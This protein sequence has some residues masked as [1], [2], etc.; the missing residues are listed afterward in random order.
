MEPYPLSQLVT[1]FILLCFGLVVRATL[2]FLETSITAMR[3]YRLKE[4]AHT[5]TQYLPLLQILEK[6]PQR[7][8]I[9][10]IVAN[11]FVDVTAA[12]LAT[13]IMGKIFMHIGFSGS[14][15]FTVGIAFATICIIVF[16]EILPKSFAK[17]RSEQS[18]QSMLW[19]I[20]L[21]YY[22][23]YPLVFILVRFSDYVM[24]KIGGKEALE[25]GTQW[26]SSEREI[27]FLINYIHEQ[28]LLELEKREMLQNIFEMGSTPTKEV[29]V[30]AT[31]IVSLEVHTPIEKVFE[32]FSKHP[33][34][35]IPVYEGQPDNFIGMAH[36]KDLFIMFSKNET[37]S[38][39]ELIRPIMF[40]PESMKVNQLLGKFREK[41]MHIGIVINE[42]G[43]VTGLVTLEDIIEEIVGEISDEHEPTMGKIMPLQK[44]EWIVDA[45][46]PLNDLG[47]FLGITFETENSVSLA[48]FLAEMLQHIPA[49][50]EKL[51]YKNFVFQVHKA[52]PLRVQF[53]FI[54]K[55]E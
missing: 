18:F 54:T 6:T 5:T 11:N 55:T 45:T 48:G 24:Y 22:A 7:I 46:I 49:K 35:R 37:K 20:N 42:H 10:I 9:T 17:V 27:Q 36:Q 25:S 23:L 19:L 34:T 43:G 2:S 47:E 38:L 14:V 3:L 13:F 21:V 12:S 44:D 39:K 4:L 1:P 31:N 41:Q 33:Y 26:V 51:T 32:F 30:P 50:D 15:G 53:V 29:M 8:L 16:G 28:G 52:T 40:I